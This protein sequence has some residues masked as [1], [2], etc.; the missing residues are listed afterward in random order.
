MTR[1]SITRFLPD[2]EDAA[3]VSGL[4]L[5]SLGIARLSVAWAMITAGTLIFALGLAA[6]LLSLHRR[7]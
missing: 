7:G 1:Q 5:L 2:R 3:T 6:A 4:V